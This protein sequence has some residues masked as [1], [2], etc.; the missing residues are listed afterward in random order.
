MVKVKRR[1]YLDFILIYIKKELKNIYFYLFVRR[2]VRGFDF[3]GF[4]FWLVI[5]GGV[6]IFGVI[7]FYFSL[8][9]GFLFLYLIG[10]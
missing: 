5:I 9:I 4:Y 8:I 2:L 1:C 10:F 7:D 3:S 6:L